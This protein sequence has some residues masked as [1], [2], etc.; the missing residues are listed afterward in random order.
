MRPRTA[1]LGGLREVIEAAQYRHVKLR[2][3]A[4]GNKSGQDFAALIDR[5]ILRSRGY[6]GLGQLGD[7]R[8]CIG[9]AMRTVETT[10]ES[11]GKSRSIV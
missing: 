6:A 5:A 9:E 10:E 11:G 8:R 2:A 3:V 4:V 1:A 7:A